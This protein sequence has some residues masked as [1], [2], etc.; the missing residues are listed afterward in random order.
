MVELFQMA[1]AGY[2][3]IATLALRDKFNWNTPMPVTGYVEGA[4]YAI[5]MFAGI[6]CLFIP[7]K[8]RKVGIILLAITIVLIGITF[9]V[10]FLTDYSPDTLPVQAIL[11]A[12]LSIVLLI[13][14]RKSA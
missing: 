9:F 5:A 6:V 2:P 14:G 8:R 3:G 13:L 11:L 10:A 4:V 1:I 7:S 12:I